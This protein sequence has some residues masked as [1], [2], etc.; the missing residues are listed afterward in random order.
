[1]ETARGTI[2]NPSLN[3]GWINLVMQHSGADAA[4]HF[5]Q[6]ILESDD[7]DTAAVVNVLAR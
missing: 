7:Q 6:V 3:F 1:M 4:L 2:I 5:V